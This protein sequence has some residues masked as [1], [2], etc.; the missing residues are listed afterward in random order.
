M[1]NGGL[2]AVL[3]GTM[4]QKKAILQEIIR[5]ANEIHP[6]RLTRQTFIEKSNIPFARVRYHYGS[7]NG[8]VKE[9]GL[10]PNPKGLPATGYKR[11][12]EDELL[13]EIG[14]LWQAKGARPSDNV[15]NSAGNFSVRPYKKRWGSFGA[16]VDDYVT[17]RGIP[18]SVVSPSTVP[19]GRPATG[20]GMIIPETHKPKDHIANKRRVLFGEPLNF[21]GLQYAPVNEQGVVYL[22]G[23][24]SRE[25]GFLIESIRTDFP[26]CEGK[27]C[28]DAEGREWEHVRIEFEYKSSRFV[29]GGHDPNGCDLIICW[30]H[31]WKD[32][33]L[34]VLELRAELKKLPK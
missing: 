12:T 26:D 19:L 33:P 16:A 32:C 25:L 27:R 31:D 29:E 2:S 3:E 24:V 6:A 5:V 22:F 11:L 8:A 7:F 4:D 20:T 30:T 34:E 13:D 10:D 28:V 18:S 15:M 14:R 23:M 1:W 9:A 17:K 21:R